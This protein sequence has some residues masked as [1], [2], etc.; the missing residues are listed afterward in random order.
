MCGSSIGPYLALGLTCRF[1]CPRALEKMFASMC[2]CTL[3][4]LIFLAADFGVLGQYLR[5]VVLKI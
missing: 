3:F 2:L 1:D 4:L 5:A